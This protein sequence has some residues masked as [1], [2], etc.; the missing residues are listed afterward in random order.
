MGYSTELA[1]WPTIQIPEAVKQHIDKFFSIMDTNSPR[2]GD[3]LAD[4]IFAKNGVMY[5]LHCAEGT[6][7]MSKLCADM[8]VIIS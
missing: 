1:E 3:R 8:R 4:E 2:A 7:C 5:S 6:E